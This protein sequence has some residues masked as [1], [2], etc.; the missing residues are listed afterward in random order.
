MAVIPPGGFSVNI[1]T[2]FKVDERESAVY[3]QAYRSIKITKGL[4]DEFYYEQD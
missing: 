1:N 3:A 2:M 4:Y